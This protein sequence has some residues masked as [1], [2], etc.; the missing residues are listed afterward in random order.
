[1][2]A[3]DQKK[4]DWDTI[5]GV[6]E[7][8]KGGLFSLSKELIDVLIDMARVQP[9]D[10]E[11]NDHI[12]QIK[13]RILNGS[14]DECDPIVVV[15]YHGKEMRLGG[16]HTLS[17]ARKA[18]EWEINVMR[19]P[20]SYVEHLNMNELRLIGNLLNPSPERVYLPTDKFSAAKM[21]LNLIDSGHKIDSTDVIRAL[22][23]MGFKSA[24]RT[25]VM[26]IVNAELKKRD[27]VRPGYT[28]KDYQ[29]VPKYE[30]ELKELAKKYR[31]KG[32]HV[33]VGT[34]SYFKI[35]NCIIDGYMLQKKG[36]KSKIMYIIH[37]TDK[38]TQK[39]W[40]K[41]L[42]LRYVP[43]TKFYLQ[44]A[45]QKLYVKEMKMWEKDAE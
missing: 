26:R 8:V 43:A 6:V 39:K 12:E 22:D 23:E 37:H 5:F 30:L 15:N 13:N 32:Y 17:A 34:S 19:I 16:N 11:D 41:Q 31:E 25:P 9:R 29:A 42:K 38:T 24:L 45:G 40:N 18:G 10:K 21:V 44:Q 27:K 1:M 7:R 28:F 4:I 3:I 2:K 14:V 33:I 36:V 20:S 35:E